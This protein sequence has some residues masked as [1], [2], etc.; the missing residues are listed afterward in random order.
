[1]P[2]SPSIVQEQKG[3]FE[4][5]EPPPGYATGLPCGSGAYIIEMNVTRESE[6][7]EPP[8]VDFDFDPDM[9]LVTEEPHCK[10]LV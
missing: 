10:S 4:P 6:K 5:P 7:E 2:T 9:D 8:L 3:V 1:M